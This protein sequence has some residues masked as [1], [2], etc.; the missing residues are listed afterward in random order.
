MLNIICNANPTIEVTVTITRALVESK[1]IS[2]NQADAEELYVNMQT[3]PTSKWQELE[4]VSK[5]IE[6]LN[7]DLLDENYDYEVEIKFDSSYIDY[8][9]KKYPSKDYSCFFEETAIYENPDL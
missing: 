5:V 6:K 8:M 7:T 1:S 9:N 2:L 4:C 3:K